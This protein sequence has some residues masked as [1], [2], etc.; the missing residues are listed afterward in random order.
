MFR[1]VQGIRAAVMIAASGGAVLGACSDSNEPG[2]VDRTHP[3]ADSVAEITVAGTPYGVAIS[4]S[5]RVYVTLL[6]T[7]RV[8]QAPSTDFTSLGDF[9]SV[10]NTPPH[11]VFAPNGEKA[12]TTNQD[13]QSFS[14]IDVSSSTVDTTV[15]LTDAAYNLIVS[16]DGKK[17]YVSQANGKVYIIRTS[18]NRIRDS[19]QLGTAV[20]GFA[21]HPS[22]SRI[23]ISSRDGGT[24]SEVDG[25]TN[26]V[27]R[28]FTTDGLPQRIAVSP[29]GS[30]LLVATELEGFQIWKLASGL[31]DTAIA[32]PAYGLGLSPDGA[33][34]YVT[35]PTNGRIR[36]F[37]RVTRHL[38]T[39]L[40]VGGLPRNVAFSRSGKVAII[41]N[42]AN[43]VTV[44]R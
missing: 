40:V 28:T 34:A 33:K 8:V 3:V 6:E 16:R 44:V 32:V 1:S 9:I 12:Y 39:T 27:L 13:G 24:V 42:E 21:R 41:T 2:D 10:D 22:D 30:E 18:D 5:G 37:D 14:V 35:D 26:D 17:L 15:A 4:R 20:N 43:F 23:Y 29:D 31:Q 7:S 25:T 19:L 11:V 36:I 38:D